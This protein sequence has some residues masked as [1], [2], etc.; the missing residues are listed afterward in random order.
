MSQPKVICTAPFTALLIDTNKGLRPCCAYE[1]KFLGNIKDELAS[2]IRSKAEWTQLKNNLARGKWPAG[3][4]AC[5]TREEATGWSLRLLFQSE[6]SRFQAPAWKDGHITYLEFSGSNICNLACLHC[7]PGYSSKWTGDYE[8]LISIDPTHPDVAQ[9]DDSFYRTYRLHKP[10]PDLIKRNLDAL[11]LSHLKTVNFKGG[12]PLLNP[13]T[14]FLLNALKERNV[15]SKIEIVLSTNATVFNEA[16]L[17]LVGEAR[18]V[19]MNVSV[20]GYGELN[21]YIRY[22]HSHTDLIEKFIHR[23]SALDNIE[24][25]RATSLMAFN[26]H[27][28]IDIRDWWLGLAAKNQ[29]VFADSPF[30]SVVMSP[31]WL[32]PIVLTENYR[33]L[34]AERLLKN[35]R[36]EEFEL[37]IYNLKTGPTNQALRMRFKKFKNSMEKIRGNS[38]TQIAPFLDQEILAD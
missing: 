24:I 27:D 7:N 19:V 31:A 2:T 8:K 11:D 33:Q 28:L 37:A 29:R 23:F 34:Q 6:Q 14:E 16:F 12:E 21:E 26:A 9:T 38:L 20:D 25:H 30:T 17:T 32:N 4:L 18:R 35:Q 3:C 1:D 36:K 10:D 5:K 15:L 22:G 13:E